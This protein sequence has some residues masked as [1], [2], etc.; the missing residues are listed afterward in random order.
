MGAVAPRAPVT[1]KRA[2]VVRLPDWDARLAALIV[3][4]SQ[5]TFAWGAHDC[6]TFAGAAVEAL[7]GDDPVADWRRRHG[8]DWVSLATAAALLPIDETKGLWGE[9]LGVEPGS[10]MRARRGDLVCAEFPETESYPGCLAYG[11]VDGLGGFYMPGKR[12]LRRLPLALASLCWAV[13]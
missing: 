3:A 10:T 11:V 8:G 1:A 6:M 7:T 4:C 9:A 2:R 5:R 12:I 13:G